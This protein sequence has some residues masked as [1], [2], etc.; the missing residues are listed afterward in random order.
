MSAPQFGLMIADDLTGALDSSVFF[1][2]RG[3]SVTVRDWQKLTAI[4][5]TWN[6]ATAGLL[7]IDTNSR[8]LQPDAAAARIVAILAALGPLPPRCLVFKK[9]DSRLKGN[10]RAETDALANGLGRRTLLVCPAVPDAGR[11]VENGMLIDG[12]TA[13]ALPRWDSALSASVPNIRTDI[14][15]RQ[16]GRDFLEHASTAIAVGSRGL[17][18]SLAEPLPQGPAHNVPTSAPIREPIAF[19]IGTND[20]VTLGQ[21]ADLRRSGAVQEVQFPRDRASSIVSGSSLLL[22]LEVTSREEF[23]QQLLPFVEWA[24]HLTTKLAMQTL[25][26]SGGD[27]L[28]ALVDARKWDGITPLR[29]LGDGLVLGQQ[30]DGTSP[31]IVSKS[32]GFGHLKALSDLAQLARRSRVDVQR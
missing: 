28:R 25:V 14:E 20:P 4:D 23:Q 8:D 16:L 19:I 2:E 18:R 29:S 13:I 1:A 22:K 6:G 21:V 32:G 31:L 30:S 11:F 10:V 5:Q 17:A 26:V 24:V 9:I 15:L 12:Q 27:T 3:W 7:V